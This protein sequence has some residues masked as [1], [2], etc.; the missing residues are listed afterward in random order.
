MKRFPLYLLA[1]LVGVL[2]LS[3]CLFSHGPVVAAPHRA[4]MVKALGA[5]MKVDDVGLVPINFANFRVNGAMPANGTML[6]GQIG[7]RQASCSFTNGQCALLFPLSSVNDS[8]A[9]DYWID[10][11]KAETTRT[12]VWTRVKIGGSLKGSRRRAVLGG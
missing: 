12:L 4:P 2:L 11:R 10:G 8:G 5:S 7:Q 6:V 9:V 3:G 1:L